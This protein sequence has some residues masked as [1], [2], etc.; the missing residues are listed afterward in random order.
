MGKPEVR[1]ALLD[2]DVDGRIKIEL[3]CKAVHKKK[4]L[5]LP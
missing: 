4:K 5:L 3:K 2:Q 1:N